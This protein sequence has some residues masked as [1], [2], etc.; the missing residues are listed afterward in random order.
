MAKGET[1]E[2]RVWIPYVKVTPENYK[3]FMK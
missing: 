1:V 3:E 2:S